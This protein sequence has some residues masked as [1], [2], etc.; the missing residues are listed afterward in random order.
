[1]Q[2]IQLLGMNTRFIPWSVL[3][4]IV[5]PSLMFMASSGKDTLKPSFELSLEVVLCNKAKQKRVQLFFKPSKWYVF[6]P[7]SNGRG[8]YRLV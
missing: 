2:N 5:R 4:C 6:P 8:V 3:R 7:R 1:M